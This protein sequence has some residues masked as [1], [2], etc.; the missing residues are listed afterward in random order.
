MFVKQ[1]IVVIIIKEQSN[2]IQMLYTTPLKNVWILFFF[3]F[4][5]FS[6]FICLLNDISSTFIKNILL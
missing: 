6:F 1:I 3:F 5:V 2:S 4:N